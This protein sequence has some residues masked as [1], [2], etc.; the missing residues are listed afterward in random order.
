MAMPAHA[1]RRSETKS[2][3]TVARGPVPCRTSTVSASGRSTGLLSSI[4][5][6][7]DADLYGLGYTAC[8]SLPAASSTNGQAS[9]RVASGEKKSRE[10]ACIGELATAVH[11][12]RLD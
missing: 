5:C 2:T 7:P 11:R 6:A 9:G 3:E 4:A 12:E 8:A 10:S 1:A